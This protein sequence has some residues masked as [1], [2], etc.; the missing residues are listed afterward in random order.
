M[1]KWISPLTSSPIYDYDLGSNHE[2]R[3]DQDILVLNL[4]RFDP[5]SVDINCPQFD[6]AHAQKMRMKAYFLQSET[7]CLYTSASPAI[8]RA[9]YHV[10]RRSDGDVVGV[11]G[12]VISEWDFV[13]HSPTVS[14]RQKLRRRVHEQP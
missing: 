4:P 11:P 3:R 2:R 9:Y 6:P 12:A 10:N 7:T 13:F 8:E 14:A 1:V 5:E